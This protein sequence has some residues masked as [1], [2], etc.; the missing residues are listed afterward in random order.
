LSFGFEYR[1]GGTIINGRNVNYVPYVQ[2][3]ATEAVMLKSVKLELGTTSTHALDKPMNWPE[4]QWKSQ[5][6]YF[7]SEAN[8]G[9]SG[10]FIG[11][12]NNILVGVYKFPRKMRLQPTITVTSIRENQAT[13]LVTTPTAF[14]VVTASDQG[15]YAIGSILPAQMNVGTN[16]GI[17]FI[18]D[19]RL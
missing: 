15:L 16:H 1:S 8:P 18:A 13:G 6:Y 17:T 12:A 5:Y 19:A 7:K 10:G 2:F 4:E 14:T 9:Q 3:V 11:I